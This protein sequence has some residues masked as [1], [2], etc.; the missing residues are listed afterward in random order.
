MTTFSLSFGGGDTLLGLLYAAVK[1]T[2]GHFDM[3]LSGD[4]HCDVTDIYLLRHRQHRVT[5]FFVIVIVI[6]IIH[7]NNVCLLVLS[8][9]TG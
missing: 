5:E 1:C 8:K 2:K 3:I 9:A 4:H 6:V 7:I